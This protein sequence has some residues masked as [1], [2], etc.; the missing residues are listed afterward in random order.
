MIA[1]C[2]LSSTDLI[3]R[4]AYVPLA[5]LVNQDC[6]GQW[7][8]GNNLRVRVYITNFENAAAAMLVLLWQSNQAETAGKREF[9]S[10]T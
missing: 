6:L 10:F 3:I 4:T 8:H 1:L 2:N 9:A 5:M 7:R